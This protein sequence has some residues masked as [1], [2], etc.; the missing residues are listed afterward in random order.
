MR[1][2]RYCDQTQSCSFC[3]KMIASTPMTCQSAMSQE[4]SIG[5]SI[6]SLPY[7]ATSGA[8]CGVCGAASRCLNSGC[9]SNLTLIRTTLPAPAR[10]RAQRICSVSI[11]CVPS[12]ATQIPL[13]LAPAHLTV[14]R[15]TDQRSPRARTVLRQNQTMCRSLALGGGDVVRHRRIDPRKSVIPR[16][17]ARY[18]V[19]HLDSRHRS[20]KSAAQGA[21]R[22]NKNCSA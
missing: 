12:L 5:N 22:R 9:R 6:H 19:G 14:I 1:P 11:S 10:V 2:R 15:K 16:L 18:Q 7:N 21:V 13:T 8:R 3:R 17:W 4:I 20:V